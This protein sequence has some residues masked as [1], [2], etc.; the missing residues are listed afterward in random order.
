MV[1][2]HSD[3]EVFGLKRDSVGYM[4]I[5]GFPQEPRTLG[6]AMVPGHHILKMEVME[7]KDEEIL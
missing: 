3:N 1:C 7:H 6:L 2:C 5:V 4:Y